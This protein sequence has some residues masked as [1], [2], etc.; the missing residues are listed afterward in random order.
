MQSFIRCIRVYARRRTRQ[1]RPFLLVL[2][3][4]GIPMAA[5]AL[6]FL[7]GE[8]T[9]TFVVD[10]LFDVLTWALMISAL[11]I[12]VIAWVAGSSPGQA[13]ISQQQKLSRLTEGQETE[14]SKMPS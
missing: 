1:A 12:M 7:V 4:L 14:A 6:Q 11:P 13:W 5:L 8:K 9:L 2:R 3:L 10:Y